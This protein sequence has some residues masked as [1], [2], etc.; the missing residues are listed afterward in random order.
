MFSVSAVVGVDG[1][2]LS[3][4]YIPVMLDQ[5]TADFNGL[6]VTAQIVDAGGRRMIIV[7]PN[8]TVSS[9]FIPISNQ[10]FN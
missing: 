3:Q 10:M 4:A 2:M 1:N 8:S 7:A 6:A 9:M 5:E